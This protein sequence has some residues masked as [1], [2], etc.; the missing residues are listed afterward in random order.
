MLDETPS[1]TRVVPFEFRGSGSEYFRIWSVNLLLTIVTLGIYS[2]WAKVRRM[3][4][5]YGS[6]R[7]DGHAFDYHAS[8]IAILKGRLIAF[9][10]Y[11][12]YAVVAQV[13][14]EKSALALIPFAIV[15]PWVI[16]RSRKFHMRMS[17]WRGLRFDFHGDYKGALQAYVGWLIAAVL[18]LYILFPVYL[19]KRIA[20]VLGNS[21]Y[22]AERFRFTTP[23]SAF[24]GFALATVGL[25]VLLA[26]GWGVA[27]GIATA[28]IGL[29]AEGT[30][31]PGGLSETALGAGVAVA[32][33][34]LVLG[35]IAISAYYSKSV[36][37]A[38]FNG[39]EVGPHRLQSTLRTAPLLRLYIE[40]FILIVLTLGLYYPWAKVATARYQ[41]EN[42]ALV[43]QGSLDEFCAA[44]GAG[45][46]ATGEEISDFFDVDFGL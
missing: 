20:Y 25:V 8:P 1:A 36:T 11:V 28:I 29:S 31:L 12:V 2:A 41:L 17:S 9:G 18:T 38:A 35:G 16:M 7:L 26:I 22:G 6:T 40:N 14:P 39:V 42:T 37:N 46:T 4:Y 45:G 19:R 32:S 13:Y 43:A 21:A 34:A 23:Q 30:K 44:A 3:R 10:L 5:F 33:L 27:F 24:W 15:L